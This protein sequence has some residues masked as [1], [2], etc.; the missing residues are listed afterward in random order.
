MIARHLMPNLP[1]LAYSLR[2]SHHQAFKL[3]LLARA[4]LKR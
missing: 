2:L 1:V 3:Y 4:D